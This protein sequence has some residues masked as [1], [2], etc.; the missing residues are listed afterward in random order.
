MKKFFDRQKI[1]EQMQLKWD[2]HVDLKY[3]QW[4]IW[5]IKI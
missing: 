3:K 5:E 4:L 1:M 2:E